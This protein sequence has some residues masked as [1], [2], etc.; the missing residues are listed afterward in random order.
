MFFICIIGNKII[1]SFKIKDGDK[2]K[3]GACHNQEALC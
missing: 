2:I 1:G 3:A